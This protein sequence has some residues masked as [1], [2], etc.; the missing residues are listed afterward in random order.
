MSPQQEREQEE[1][2][3]DEYLISTW[4]KNKISL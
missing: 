4:S 3:Q 1:K 2:E